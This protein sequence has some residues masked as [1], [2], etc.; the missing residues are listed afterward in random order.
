MTRYRRVLNAEQTQQLIAWSL[1]GRQ[2]AYKRA[3]R[4]DAQASLDSQACAEA[5]AKAWHRQFAD[6]GKM[7]VVRA[8]PSPMNRQRKLLE[9][10]CGHEVWSGIRRQTAP[11][12]TCK[13][14][15]E[16][17]NTGKES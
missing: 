12:P 2:N 10:A 15:R 17:A 4:T 16:T 1:Q 11:C 8:T 5:T 6:P 13:S 7:P 9:L 3:V 14:A